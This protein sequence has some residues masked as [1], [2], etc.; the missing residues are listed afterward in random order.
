MTGPHTRRAVTVLVVALAVLSAG[1]TGPGGP[2]D[3]TASPTASPTAGTD[4]P[5]PTAVHPSYA[6]TTVTVVDDDTGEDLGRVTAAI[7]DNGTLRYTGLSETDSLPTD[8][9]MLFLY[10]GPQSSLTYVMRNMSFPLDIV[11]VH[12]NG[13]IQSIHHVRAPEAGEDGE[14]ITASGEGQYVLE[15]N[16]GWMTDRGIE[17]GDRLEFELPDE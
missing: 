2:P 9:G 7:A 14:S 3:P 4:T 8:R 17:A 1:C 16:R 6:E 5:T 10:D 11:F 12:A 13:T 15:V